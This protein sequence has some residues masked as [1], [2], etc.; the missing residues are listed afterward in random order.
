MTATVGG[1][2]P[3]PP[4]NTTTFLR[5]DGTFATPAGSGDMVLANTQTNSGVKT[6]LDTTMALRNFANTFSGVFTNT[7]TAAR[8]WTLKDASG[9]IAFTSDITG[10]NSGTNTGDQT[11]TLTGG[12]TGTGTGSFAATVVTNANLTGDVTSVGNATTLTNAPVIAKV[13]TG[14]ISGAGVVAATDSILAAFQKINGN[15]AL[16]APLAS[17][18]FTGI[19]TTPAITLGAVALTSTGTELNFVTG[20]TSSIQTQLNSKQA[21]GSYEVTT[22]KDATGGYAGLTLFKINFKNAANTFTSFFTNANTA[23]RTYTFQDRDGTI[24]DNTDLALKANL[25]SPTFTGTVVLP[26]GQALIAPALGTPASGVM[27]NV[28]GTA[29]GLTSGIT[30]ALKSATTTVDVSASAAPSTGQVLTAT[31]GT[32][33]TWQTPSGGTGTTWTE[34]TTTSQAAAVSNGYVTNNVALVTV[35]LPASAAVG[36]I[37]YV[38]GSGAGGF[39]L[40]QNALQLIQWDAGAVAG[41]NVTTTG[42]T[43]SISSSDRYD[44]IEVMC[45]VANTT[46]VVRNS[47]GNLL[48]V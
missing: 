23:A 10:T 45:I 40:A 48:L 3:T 44:S 1:A 31:A 14:Y 5:G 20:V 36:Q 37:V 18:T 16:K 47:K 4:N 26:S 39:K 11:I 2:V 17:P 43:G 33:A 6:F 27:T 13:L 42:I 38:Q 29:T 28:I 41:L 22:N 15:D 7:I 9:T 25:A 24:S 35:T 46:F 19:V 12:V 32:T 30:L 21:T 8:V 34:V